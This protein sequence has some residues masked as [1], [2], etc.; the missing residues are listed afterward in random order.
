VLTCV[1][2]TAAGPR[3]GN[4]G[5]WSLR[6][7]CERSSKKRVGEEEAS[8]EL[9]GL[10]RQADGMLEQA[11][12][13]SR[14][15]DVRFELDDG[16]KLVGAHQSMLRSASKEFKAMF[17]IGMKEEVEGVVRMRGVGASA[18]KGLLEW[19]YLGEC[20]RRVVEN[21]KGCGHGGV[22]WRA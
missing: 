12:S 13:C 10:R 20:W 16:T 7:A 17:E 22:Y 1:T 14:H 15:A 11:L 5:K 3:L 4:G 2:G 8:G 19:V 21:L 9:R 18:V 6:G